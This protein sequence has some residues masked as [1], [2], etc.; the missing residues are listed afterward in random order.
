[1]HVYMRAYGH[2]VHRTYAAAMI[3]R[4]CLLFCCCAIFMLEMTG[5][6]EQNNSGCVLENKKAA[7]SEKNIDR[8]QN[9]RPKAAGDI[10]H[11]H[12]SATLTYIRVHTYS[13]III[14]KY[15]KIY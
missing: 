13:G 7:E 2:I 9:E 14:K 8:M 3:Q 5:R 1:M 12:S 15:N 6:E 10:S 11:Q 4:R